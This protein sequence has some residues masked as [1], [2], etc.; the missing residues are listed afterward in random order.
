MVRTYNLL[1]KVTF[2]GNYSDEE[3]L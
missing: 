2:L 3:N 1:I